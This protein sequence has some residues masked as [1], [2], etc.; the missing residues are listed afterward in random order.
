[1]ALE[2][3]QNKHR[4]GGLRPGRIEAKSYILKNK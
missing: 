4:S 2:G 3:V 1:M